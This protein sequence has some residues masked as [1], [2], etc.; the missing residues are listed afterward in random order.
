MGRFGALGG[1]EEELVRANVVD[2]GHLFVLASGLLNGERG[3]SEKMG[4][5]VGGR[6][7]DCF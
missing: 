1:I 2:G 4:E 5:E 7:G 3:R 6:R